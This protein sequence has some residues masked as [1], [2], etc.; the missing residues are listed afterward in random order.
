MDQHVRLE[1]IGTETGFD[2]TTTLELNSVNWVLKPI[3]LVSYFLFKFYT[4][5]C[6]CFFLQ[7]HLAFFNIARMG[8]QMTMWPQVVPGTLVLGLGFRL[9]ED[10]FLVELASF[11]SLQ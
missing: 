5:L 8:S 10:Q 7:N 11:D 1:T 2:I 6:L 3:N 9:V 4:M